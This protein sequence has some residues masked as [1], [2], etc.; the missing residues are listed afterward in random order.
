LA[1][2]YFVTS[3]KKPNKTV[4]IVRSKILQQ[5]KQN[6]TWEPYPIEENPF[7]NYTRNDLGKLL[8]AELTWT[9]DNIMMLTDFDD[10]SIALPLSFDSR[11]QWPD[12][13]TPIRNQEHCGS[14]W[15]FSAT[16]ALT[17]RFCIA[18][19]GKSK[20]LLSPQYLVS[21]DSTNLAC[22]GGLLDRVW[23]F[24]E[25][26]GVVSETCFTYKSGDGK[27]IPK[28][29]KTCDQ[30]SEKLV[31]YKAVQGSSKPL[32][33]ATQLQNE[34]MTN[35]PVITGFIVYEDFM[36][37]KSGIYK[38]STGNKLGGHAVRVVG[39]GS[40]NNQSYWIVANSWGPSWA[41]NGYFRIAFGECL[42]E[43]NG[44]TGLADTTTSKLFLK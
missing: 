44:Y 7:K 15:A 43:A 34:I 23:T 21:C 39:W 35:G 8:G 36:H 6:A 41:E 38:H 37:Y 4:S 24:L 29:P 42:F 17:D 1:L 9:E 10:H 40:E 12:C 28:C 19:K 31:L 5:V 2:I 18:S 25:K 30:T 26:N 13:V 27:N 14:C 20:V 32:T 22:H 11:T 3:Q 16:T 33:C